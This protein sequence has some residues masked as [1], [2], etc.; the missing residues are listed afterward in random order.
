MS[1]ACLNALTEVQQ[2]HFDKD[3]RPDLII[4]SCCPGWTSTGMSSFTGHS[5]E[6][7]KLKIQK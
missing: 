1:K 7:G 6:E 4:N 3:S 5:T 2:R